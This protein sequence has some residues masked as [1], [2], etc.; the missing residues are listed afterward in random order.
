[1]SPYKALFGQELF[2]GLE[3]LNKDKAESNKI[4]TIKQLYTALGN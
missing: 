3:A 1:M 4:S 2:V